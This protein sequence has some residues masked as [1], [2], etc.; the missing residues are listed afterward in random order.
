MT[1][2]TLTDQAEPQSVSDRI[3]SKFGFPSAKGV[4][5]QTASEDGSQ[6]GYSAAEPDLFELNFDGETFKVPSKLKDAFLRNEDYTRKT[7]ELAEQ[8]RA[9]EH[10]RELAQT[11]QL[12]AVFS[13]SVAQETKELA[14][15]DA[16]LQQASKVDWAQMTTDQILRHK[17]EIDAIKERRESIKAEIDGKRAKFSDEVNTKLK[18]L[19]GK[20]RELVSKKINGFSEE[21]ESAM[22]K[23]AVAEGLSELEVDNVL[24]DPRSA[25]LIW[26]A[27]QFDQVKAGT[28][29]AAEATT[30]AARV[31]KPGGAGESQSAQNISNMNF[32]K[33]MKAAGNNSSAKARV[34][35]DRLAGVFAR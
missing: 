1:T 11:K 25:Q 8:R 7:Q 35:E 15:I 20:S 33:A 5:E 24:L 34:I 31:L 16:Y 28:T 17:V 2:E 3:A 9:V 26:K 10:T 4:P 18:E 13:E 6:D 19:R 12:E 21:T 23:Y 29:K 32:A 30:K 14:I 27:M 22:R